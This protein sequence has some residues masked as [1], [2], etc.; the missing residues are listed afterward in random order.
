MVAPLPR[1][2]RSTLH[3]VSAT[4][5]PVSREGQEELFARGVTHQRVLAPFLALLAMTGMLAGAELTTVG[6]R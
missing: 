6:V 3:A 4:G 2:G 1:C 5:C